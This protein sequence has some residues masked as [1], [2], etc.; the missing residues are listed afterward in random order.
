MEPTRLYVKNVLAALAPTPSRP[1][2]TSPAVVCWKTFPACCP[3]GMAAHLQKG[4]WPQTE[5][6]AWLQKPP[7]LTTSK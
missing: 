4:S 7:A 5:L 1:W 6:F 2:P 3:T